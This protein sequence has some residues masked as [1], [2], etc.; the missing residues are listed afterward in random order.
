MKPVPT[1]MLNESRE[2]SREARSRYPFPLFFCFVMLSEG[3]AKRN[4]LYFYSHLAESKK[5]SSTTI[6]N[7]T[8]ALHSSVCHYVFCPPL[9]EVVPQLCA[10]TEVDVLV[11]THSKKRSS[12]TNASRIHD[13]LLKK[14]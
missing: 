12:T 14:L 3:S 1:V 11:F 2:G 13:F 7:P 5:R 8:A 10:G 6:A 9:A 4:I